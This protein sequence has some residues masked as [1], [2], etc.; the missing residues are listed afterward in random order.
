MTLEKVTNLI[1]NKNLFLVGRFHEAAMRQI[2]VAFNLLH[3]FHNHDY[4][5]E[6]SV[7]ERGGEKSS[8]QRFPK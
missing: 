7:S 3:D 4:Y 8:P 5:F 6:Y 1:T 2:R